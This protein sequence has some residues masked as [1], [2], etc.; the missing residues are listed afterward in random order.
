MKGK[1]SLDALDHAILALLSQDARISNRRIAAE[2][3]VSEGT[4]RLRMQRLEDAGIMH[5]TAVTHIKSLP[6]PVYAFVGLEVDGNRRRAVAEALCAMPELRCVSLIFGRYDVFA[7]VQT[8]TPQDLAELMSAR[9]SVLPGV[10]RYESW[11]GLE[12]IKHDHRFGYVAPGTG[13][14]N[15]NENGDR[16]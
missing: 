10:R 6:R 8:G 14:R 2:V 7:I 12:V 9:I 16:K 3:G 4:V 13:A 11:L 15:A 5:V 1:Q